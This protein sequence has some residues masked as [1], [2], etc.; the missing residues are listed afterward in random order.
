MAEGSD[1]LKRVI[2]QLV[3][4][5][6]R[7]IL[8]NMG[9][10]SFVDSSGIGALVVSNAKLKRAGGAIGLVDLQKR[11]EDLIELTRLTDA[12]SI[13]IDEEHGLRSFATPLGTAL[14]SQ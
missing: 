2:D 7:Q 6:S 3:E 13:F 12:F 8:L 11:V 4:S 9:G 10:V 14:P 1:T 5:G